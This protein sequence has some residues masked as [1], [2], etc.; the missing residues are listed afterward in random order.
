MIM[1]YPGRT[2]RFQTSPELEFQ[3]EQNDIRIAA[4]TVR[5]N[6]MLEQMLADPKVNSVCE[7]ILRFFKRL[8]EVAGNETRFRQT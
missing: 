5:Q 1:G 8:E 3:I 6:V 7:Q 4:R 2:T